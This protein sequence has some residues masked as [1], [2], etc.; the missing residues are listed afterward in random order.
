MLTDEAKVLASLG[1]NVS[2]ASGRTGQV[3]DGES[4]IGMEMVGI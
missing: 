1:V 4:D 3:D 2:A